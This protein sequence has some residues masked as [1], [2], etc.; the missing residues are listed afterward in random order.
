MAVRM[1]YFDPTGN[2]NDEMARRGVRGG[3]LDKGLRRTLTQDRI[4]APRKPAAPARQSSRAG[5]IRQDLTQGRIGTSGGG[6]RSTGSSSRGSYSTGGG[7]GN[8]GGFT[9]PPAVSE[10]DYL[11]GDA[12]YQAT[13]SALLKQ[14]QRFETDTEE[15]RQNRQ[16]DYNNA[17]SDLGWSDGNWDFQDTLTASGRAY[18]NLLNDFAARGMLQSTG[19]AD[20]Q[21]DLT[22]SLNDQRT[23]IDTS[24]T[25]FNNDLD[26]QLA[27]T[28]EEN[29]AAQQAARAEAIAR[30]AA[31]MGLGV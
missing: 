2:D 1:G 27:N 14:L 25:R 18:Q 28:R 3:G 13:L 19:Y 16:L 22:R 9:D 12:T 26:R 21:S 11:A 8:Y 10:E 7:T 23:G 31:S 17:L 4:P 5:Q 6:S 20:A 15:Q 30:R 29:T 24:N